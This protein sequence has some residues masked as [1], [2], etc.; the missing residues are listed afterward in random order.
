MRAAQ[1]IDVVRDPRSAAHDAQ[2]AA[3]GTTGIALIAVAR[4]IRVGAVPVGGPLPH[5][6]RHVVELQI[7]WR[8]AADRTRTAMTLQR[9]IR[10]EVRARRVD[11]VAPGIACAVT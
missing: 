4:A 8:I 2:R 5:V 1:L 7:V 9:R 6:P 3:A 11:I 10:K